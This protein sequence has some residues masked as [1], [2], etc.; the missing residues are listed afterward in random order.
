MCMLPL[1]TCN[2]YGHTWFEYF[3]CFM[4]WFLLQ[5]RSET[6]SRETHNNE[7]TNCKKTIPDKNT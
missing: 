2:L 1:C 4:F 7:P 6:V 5:A 3:D